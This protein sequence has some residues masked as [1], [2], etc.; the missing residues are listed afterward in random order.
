MERKDE[1]KPKGILLGIAAVLPGADSHMASQELSRG[2][3][4]EC[5]PSPSDAST[6]RS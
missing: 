5:Q 2:P 4:P 3:E 1:T 6:R